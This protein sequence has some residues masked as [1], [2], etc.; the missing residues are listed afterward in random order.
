M[1]HRNYF[2]KML[3]TAGLKEYLGN[4]ATLFLCKYKPHYSLLEIQ[5]DVPLW[6][7]KQKNKQ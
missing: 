4:V 1:Y 3:I 6:N 5:R 7:S 2:P